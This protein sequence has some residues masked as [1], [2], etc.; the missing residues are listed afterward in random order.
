MGVPRWEHGARNR[1]RNR[2]RPHTLRSYIV[3]IPSGTLRRNRHHLTEMPSLNDSE[4]NED[5]D[6]S[7]KECPHLPRT[8]PGKECLHLP[9]RTDPH[10]PR[11]TD[12]Q[13]R[14]P[15]YPYSPI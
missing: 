1:N 14:D 15:A 7:G 2:N 3:K 11:R 8:R 5:P 10:L 13:K 12:I 9:R 4:D 6:T